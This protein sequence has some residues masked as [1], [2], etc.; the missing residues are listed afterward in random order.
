MNP[1][2]KQLEAF[3][4]KD[5]KAFLDCYS[6]DT[7]A[8][9]LEANENINDGKDQLKNTMEKSFKSKPNAKTTV[10]ERI[11]QNDLVIDLEEVIDYIEGKIVKSVAIYEIKG[12]KITK[13]W[14]GGRTVE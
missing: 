3:N 11:T 10:I 5:L 9:M 13:I 12:G 1:V 7:K 2:D 6:E 14:F 4:R 8:F